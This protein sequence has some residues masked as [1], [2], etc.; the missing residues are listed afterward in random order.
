MIRFNG[1]ISAEHFAA[2]KM[3]CLKWFVS[4]VVS[5]S[6]ERSF[7][8]LFASTLRPLRLNALDRKDR[9]ELAKDAKQSRRLVY[10]Y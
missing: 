10:N 3:R 9:Q 8:A 7:S 1:R 2:G 4:G 6:D 5:C